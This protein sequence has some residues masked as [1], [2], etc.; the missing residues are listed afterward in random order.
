[1]KTRLLVTCGLL[2]IML[3]AAKPIA[4]PPD[5]GFWSHLFV[6][7]AANDPRSALPWLRQDGHF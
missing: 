7:S 6:G 2:T 4:E 3:V 1:M 5:D